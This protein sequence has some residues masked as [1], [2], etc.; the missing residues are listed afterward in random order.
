[1]LSQPADL[2]SAGAA[3]SRASQATR[4]TALY[5]YEEQNHALVPRKPDAALPFTA[6]PTHIMTR[7][8][9]VSVPDS[10]VRASCSLHRG[11]GWRRDAMFIAEGCHVRARSSV[12]GRGRQRNDLHSAVLDV[13]GRAWRQ[14]AA[15]TRDAGSMVEAW[16]KHTCLM[17]QLTHMPRDPP[18]VQSRS[19]RQ[20]AARPPPARG[21]E[22]HAPVRLWWQNTARR[23]CTPADH[24]QYQTTR[25]RLA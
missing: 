24:R 10:S 3:C 23:Q 5:W 13:R 22:P 7:Q 17:R 20:C 1:M 8:L 16:T 19:F 15:I 14:V 18:E 12:Q 6:P 2:P 21:P 11:G 9:A 25:S 4:S